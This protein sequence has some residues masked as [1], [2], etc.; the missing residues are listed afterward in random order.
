MSKSALVFVVYVYTYIN[1]YIHI[2]VHQHIHILAKVYTYTY[3]YTYKNIYTYRVSHIC[4]CIREGTENGRAGT[5]MAA[6]ASTFLLRAG[7]LYDVTV[8]G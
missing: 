2:H 8:G 6:S 1:T 5:D 7:L 3:I 4:T